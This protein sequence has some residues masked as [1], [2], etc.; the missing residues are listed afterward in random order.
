MMPV[1]SHHGVWSVGKGVVTRAPRGSK[2]A[3]SCCVEVRSVGVEASGKPRARWILAKRLAMSGLVGL[4]TLGSLVLAFCVLT[5]RS[6][7][8]STGVV[9][10]MTSHDGVWSL[11]RLDCFV[12]LDVSSRFRARRMLAARTRRI[13]S[14]RD[15]TFVVVAHASSEVLCTGTLVD[16]DVPDLAGARWVKTGRPYGN[17]D[18]RGEAQ[19]QCAVQLRRAGRSSA[20]RGRSHVG[21]TGPGPK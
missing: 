20:R 9:L 21:C 6:I 1:T 12:T 11:P 8:A 16:V 2:G 17:D 5:F 19:C 7:G 10:A 15:S 14:P 18:I 13:G 3:R 4:M